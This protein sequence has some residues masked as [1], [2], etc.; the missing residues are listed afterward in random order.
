MK[1]LFQS[2]DPTNCP[3]DQV[4]LLDS[5]GQPY[6]GDQFQINTASFDFEVHQTYTGDSVTLKIKAENIMG[7]ASE[8]QDA[9]VSVACGNEMVS[10]ADPNPLVIEAE[11]DET[12]AL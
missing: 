8:T 10:P 4:T 2:S 3:I 5:A 12:I 11:K 1:S 7:G 6:T 9:V